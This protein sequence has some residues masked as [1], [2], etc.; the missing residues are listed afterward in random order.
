MSKG[1]SIALNGFELNVWALF[2]VVYF[3]SFVALDSIYCKALKS[4]SLLTPETLSFSISI[5]YSS[6][7]V[8]CLISGTFN[9][10]S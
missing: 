3:D 2:L 5:Q 8:E 6:E 10:F 4:L 7:V 1:L 9:N